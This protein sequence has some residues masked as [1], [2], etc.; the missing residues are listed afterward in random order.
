MRQKRDVSANRLPRQGAVPS[1][2]FFAPPLEKAA[3][4]EDGAVL[5]LEQMHR[6]G[7]FSRSTEE[8]QAHRGLS[9]H[10]VIELSAA[11]LTERG[12]RTWP[13]ASEVPLHPEQGYSSLTSV[14][15]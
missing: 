13:G 1:S 11:A 9:F 3:I 5:D 6:T 14:T 7:D 4:D 15:R 2:R 12:P 8:R 10:S